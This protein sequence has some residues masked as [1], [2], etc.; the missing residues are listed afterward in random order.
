MNINTK[1]SAESWSNIDPELSKSY[2]HYYSKSMKI[3]LA[4][5]IKTL[6][7][8]KILDIGCGNAQIY[9]ILKQ[10]NPHLKYYGIDISQNL[11]NVAANVVSDSDV[12][13]HKNIYDFLQHTTDRFDVSILCHMV[14]CSESVEFLI[15]KSINTCSYLAII[16]FDY[17]KY[18]YDSVYINHN[19]HSGDSNEFKPYIR[20]K[21]GR[22]YWNMVVSKNNLE[23]VHTRSSNDS[24]V[25]EIYKTKN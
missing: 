6:N 14:E 15:S 17:P 23:L 2:L 4:E 19:P 12:L 3:E 16:W 5:F 20:R 9:P 21:I 1:I 24:D 10:T 25:L 13:I 8:P 18:E 7:Q 22:D 11:L